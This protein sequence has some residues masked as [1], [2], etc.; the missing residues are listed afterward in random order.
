[1]FHYQLIGEILF[2]KIENDAVQAEVDHLN[3]VAETD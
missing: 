2:Q 3:S 1:M